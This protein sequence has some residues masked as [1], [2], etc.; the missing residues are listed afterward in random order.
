[1]VLRDSLYLVATGLIVGLPLAWLASKAMASMLY[2]LSAH[3]PVS[4]V[5]AG[6]GVLLVSLAAALIPAQRAASVEPMEALRTE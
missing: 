3:D 1:M 2:N 5:A 4:F 6:A